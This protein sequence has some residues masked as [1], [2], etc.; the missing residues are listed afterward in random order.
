MTAWFFVGAFV[1]GIL[2]GLSIGHS[3]GKLHGF[4]EYMRLSAI[5]NEEGKNEL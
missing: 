4:E 2:M 3:V 1:V 5:Q